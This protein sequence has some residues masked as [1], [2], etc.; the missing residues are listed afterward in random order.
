MAKK[1]LEV[2][3]NLHITDE[4]KE[5]LN[6]VDVEKVT[7][8]RD[9]SSIRVYLI[10]PRLIHKQNIYS[11]EKGIKEQLFPSKQITIKIIERFRLSGQYTPQ[12][13]LKIYR[14][15]LLAELK[16]Y[17]IIEYN[18]F[19]KAQC[20]FPEPD[21][22]KMTVEDTI[23]THEKA[24]ELKRVLEKIFHERCGLPVEVQY[25]FIE[26][27]ENVLAKQKELQMQREVEEIVS[28]TSF[29][30]QQKSQTDEY[31]GPSMADG[32]LDVL[33][34]TYS[35][36]VPFT[37][38]S[39]P[40]AATLRMGGKKEGD[41]K[42]SGKAAESDSGKKEWKDYRKNSY[43]GRRSDNPDVLYGR[44][45]EEET[46]EIEKIDGEIGEVVVRGKIIMTDS[47]ELRSGK[48]I[49]IF[50]VTDFTDTITVKM[51]AREEQL[52]DLKNA[53]VKGTF[54]KIK[55][56]TTIDKF[57]GELTLGSVVGI[58]KSEDFTGKRSDN[59][60]EKRVELHCHT[61]MSD[62]DGVSEVK[63][64]VKRAKKWGMPA[65]AITDHGCVQSFPD[66]NHALDKGDT[67]KVIYGVEGY[68]VDDLKQLVEN[69]RNQT[70]SDSYVV[71]DIETTGFS[72][73]RNRIIEIGA[74]KVIDG[75]IKDK[76]SAFV[77]PDVPIPFE[78]EQ[79]TGINDSMVLPHP[80]ID[81]IL[82]PVSGVLQRF[83][84]SCPQCFV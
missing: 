70:F 3:P 42:E 13:L 5:L 74:V 79:L 46:M 55:G 56:V 34:A 48:T 63:D 26:P 47:R 33:A 43:N 66:A 9:R 62:M 35:D 1:F 73:S 81:V 25:E 83:C 20:Q 82:P 78:I 8:N 18:M 50:D 28:R 57:D 29:A 80:K 49:I 27:K 72:S 11:L 75:K 58:K 45:F 40:S 19:R 69:S 31:G 67:F 39:Q 15:S 6:L 64:L 2:F 51:F 53:V 12:K 41:K 7:S 10:S 60:L 77:N 71:F 16:N 14:E 44:D 38:E 32:P 23:V 22:L 17:S 21:L 30:G 84:F 24:G 65:L 4:L 37:Q 36:E 61:K 54:I 52:D 68:L 59:S 76:F